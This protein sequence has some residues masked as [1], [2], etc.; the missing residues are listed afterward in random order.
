MDFRWSSRRTRTRIRMELAARWVEMWWRC[1]WTLTEGRRFLS[2]IPTNR[3]NSGWKVGNYCI[4][5]VYTDIGFLVSRVA[6]FCLTFDQILN[7]ACCVKL[8]GKTFR[9]FSSCLLVVSLRRVCGCCYDDI[10]C[11][12]VLDSFH[13][14]RL[15]DQWMCYV[16]VTLMTPR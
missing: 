8:L 3:S 4:D 6:I 12:S 1:R 13:V 16:T 2:L 15:S 5:T 10:V 9:F 14:E 7:R 11:I